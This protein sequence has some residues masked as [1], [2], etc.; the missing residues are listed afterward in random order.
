MDNIVKI[1]K[2][3]L[4]NKGT[5]MTKWACVACDQFTSEPAYWGQLASVVGNAPSTLRLIFPEVYLGKDDQTRIKSINDTMAQY[6]EEG[7]FNKYEGLI[8]VKRTLSNNH[9]RLGLMIAID[10]EHYNYTQKNNALIK[11]T[12]RTV[13]ERLPARINV[14]RNAPLELPHV[15]VLLDDPDMNIIESLYADCENFEELYDFKLN[16]EGG[17]VTGFA[18]PEPRVTL[19]KIK[20]LLNDDTSYAK[21]GSEDKILFAVGDGNHS[22][23]TAKE[24]WELTK[25][26]LSPSECADH[27]GRFALVELVNLHD[28][29]LVFEPIHRVIF[30][31]TDDFIVNMALHLSGDARIKAMYKDEEYL[32][33]VPVNPS[34]AINDIQSF[35][36][37]YIDNNP[38][39]TQ[40]YIHGDDNL[41]KVAK[42]EMGI[43]IFMPTLSKSTLFEYSIRRGVLPR[44]SFS[45]GIA[46]DKRY[47]LEARTIK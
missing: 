39:V 10:L 6:V 37:D 14:R 17:R 35:I 9:T 19:N 38:E 34:D 41:I 43:A 24:C 46:E 4:P 2:I 47:Y 45:M 27:P 30:N 36:D 31:A 32:I 3:L 12:E 25:K 15:M 11:A 29:S 7:I 26:T 20:A 18:V 22:L 16:M 23:A 44:K 42:R 1:P 13:I 21:Y 40:D 8:L 28:P 5:D 33:N